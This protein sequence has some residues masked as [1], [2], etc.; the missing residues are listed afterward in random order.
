[1]NFEY[2]SNFTLFVLVVSIIL[3][4]TLRKL[5]QD[6][7]SLKEGLM[8]DLSNFTRELI[9]DHP[10]LEKY[11]KMALMYF[12]QEMFEQALSYFEHLIHERVFIREARY[13]KVICLM[14]M[15]R[16]SEALEVYENLDLGQYSSEEVHLM[17]ASF[18]RQNPLI[19]WKDALLQILLTNVPFQYLPQRD[20]PATREAEI[21]R[22]ITSLPTRYSQVVLEAEQDD[23][24]IFTGHD[25]H[26]ERKVKL[27]VAH[28]DSQP[29]RFFDYPKILARLDSRFFPEVYDLQQ[30]GLVY[31]SQERF[32][33]QSL[34]AI[35]RKN[36]QEQRLEN[37][38]R[39]WISIIGGLRFLIINKVFLENFD[40]SEIGLHARK[41]NLFFSGSLCEYSL[42]RAKK[43]EVTALEV[44][45]INMQD[46]LVD[47][48]E[49][50]SRR[51]WMKGIEDLKQGGLDDN[52]LVLE[53]MHSKM[54]SLKQA[55]KGELREQL[56]QIEKI[57]RAS[58]HGLKGKYSIVRR[59]QGNSSKLLK[60]F[61]R[62]SNLHDIREKILRL[63]TYCEELRLMTDRQSFGVCY[64]LLSLDL[65][66]LIQR[67]ESLFQNLSNDT[68]EI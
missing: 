24:Y 55:D 13:Y 40:L 59:Y 10:T 22:V 12:R 57:H 23:M 45:L 31:Y 65:D 30:T 2:A 54:I 16:S 64:D 35:F 6:I 33:G 53:E 4:F 42:D 48:D 47:I 60:T 18:A 32:E 63:K 5:I 52:Y 56:T 8:L 27:H 46:A 58:I 7:Q 3:S 17:R 36:R 25:Q 68:P 61:F 37:T 20:S 50:E 44:L 14:R 28:P 9:E 21:E 39:I 67:Q 51:A 66:K 43:V 34:F 29:D 1:M 26:L 19:R 38:L 49:S 41:N 15:K 11:R 62:M